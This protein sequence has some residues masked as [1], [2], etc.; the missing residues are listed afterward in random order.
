[1]KDKQYKAFRSKPA[2]HLNHNFDRMFFFFVLSA[3]VQKPLS[4][5][6]FWESRKDGCVIGGLCLAAVK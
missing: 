1:V 5:H 6:F 4:A 2:N 3:Q